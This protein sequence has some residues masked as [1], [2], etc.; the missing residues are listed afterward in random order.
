MSWAV[1][2]IQSVVLVYYVVNDLA[3][4]GVFLVNLWKLF[5]CLALN[6]NKLGCGHFQLLLQ[7]LYSLSELQ[8]VIFVGQ[9]GRSRKTELKKNRCWFYYRFF[10]I[11]RVRKLYKRTRCIFKLRSSNVDHEL[12]NSSD[13]QTC[14]NHFLCVIT[15]EGKL[16]TNILSLCP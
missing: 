12:I 15:L 9:N 6:I 2:S 16:F 11:W 8:E 7:R 14:P 5:P 3:Y 13:W 10:F 1:V 4:R